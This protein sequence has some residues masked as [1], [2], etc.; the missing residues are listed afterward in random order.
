[1]KSSKAAVAAAAPAELAEFNNIVFPSRPK[2][3]FRVS[4]EPLEDNNK[5][6]L[7]LENKRTRLQYELSVCNLKKH[8][9]E[10]VPANIVGSL[11]QKALAN[12]EAT[13]KEK[14]IQDEDI[15]VDCAYSIEGVTIDLTLNM[16]SL[17]FPVYSFAL[18]KKDVGEIEIIKSQLKDSLE[19][20]QTLQKKQ[21]AVLSLSSALTTANQA[22][23]Q[24]NAP[25][26]RII[27]L[28][29]FTV[30]SDSSQI[31]IL[32]KGIYQVCVRLAGIN[33]GN[34]GTSV[35][36]FLNDVLLASCIQ[37]DANGFQNS[38]H[39]NQI[40]EFEAEDNLSVKSGFNNGSLADHTHNT[41]CI[42]LL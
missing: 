12:C 42:S 16:S 38:A 1:M 3:S 17:W 29:Y 41:F 18:I 19:D 7:W 11:L 23:V 34:S 15:Q 10:G 25:D 14:K 24:W 9:P 33:T 39:L 28:D 4:F 40:F 13:N 36:L 37:S 35:T 6:K 31:T 21:S 5:W 26:R 22:I 27:N 20:I 2:E 8:G 32:K 30:T